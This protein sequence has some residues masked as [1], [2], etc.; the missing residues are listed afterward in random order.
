M[1]FCDLRFSCLCRFPMKTNSFQ[2]ILECSD[3]RRL[4]SQS[5][6]VLCCFF[7]ASRSP[8][9]LCYSLLFSGFRWFVL[10]L[11]AFLRYFGPC[12]DFS[13][14][15][16]LSGLVPWGGYPELMWWF[17][18]RISCVTLW[19]AV[20]V[21]SCLK[22]QKLRQKSSKLVTSVPKNS[23]ENLVF[24]KFLHHT[25]R[26]R[27]LSLQCASCRSWFLERIM[28]CFFVTFVF[29]ASAGFP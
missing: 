29:P 28:L 13:V 1:L 14:S 3:Y 15:L 7:S 6:H 24:Y 10:L 17:L 26:F 4:S 22:V 2:Q 20:R 9:G 11:R 27:G 16:R 12:S 5:H 18:Q 25:P 23:A 21:S 8:H 19:C